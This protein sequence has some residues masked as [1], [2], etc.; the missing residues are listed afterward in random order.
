[1]LSSF[2]VHIYPTREIEQKLPQVEEH[3]KLGATHVH[4]VDGNK[5]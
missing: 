4:D 1:M 2:Q 3:I 5:P